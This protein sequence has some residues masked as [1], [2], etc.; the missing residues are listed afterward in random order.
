MIL[1]DDPYFNEPGYESSAGTA[2]GKQKSDSYNR[3]IRQQNLRVALLP[4]LEKPPPAFKE[5]LK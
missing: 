4:M 3:N 5:V 2:G 1:I